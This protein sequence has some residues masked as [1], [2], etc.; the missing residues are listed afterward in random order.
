MTTFTH[1]VDSSS[2]CMHQLLYSTFGNFID[3]LQDIGFTI[4]AYVSHDICSG[5]HVVD[6]L[7]YT[8]W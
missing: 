6:T 3:T 2:R 5:G 4:V 1:T 7:P 8:R